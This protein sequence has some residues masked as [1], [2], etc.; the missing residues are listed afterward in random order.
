MDSIIKESERN[1][2]RAII[3]LQTWKM[4]KGA[5][6][7]GEPLH[8]AEWRLAI[9]DIAKDVMKEQT[10]KKLREIREKVYD[11]LINCIPGEYIVKYV[12]EELSIYADDRLKLQL[13]YWAAYH[14]V[15]MQMGNKPIFHIEA[16]LARIMNIFKKSV[17]NFS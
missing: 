15:R 6:G 7:E 4:Q 3:L 11:L 9:R 14:E 16:F 12:V 10:A 5:G 1:L 8:V 2:R 13:L 17:E